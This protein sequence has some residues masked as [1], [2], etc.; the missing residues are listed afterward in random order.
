DCDSH[1][2][3]SKG[4]MKITMKKYCKKDY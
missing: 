2:K 4:K 1:C 3:A